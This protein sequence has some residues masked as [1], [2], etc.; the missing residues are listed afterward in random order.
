MTLRFFPHGMD[1]NPQLFREIKGRCT[2]RNLL[3][4]IAASAG[5]QALVMMSF[6]RLLPAVD[7]VT[8]TYC[9][10]MQDGYWRPNCVRD[11]LG[12]PLI[13]WP[14]WWSDSFQFLSWMLV[15]VGLM[16]GVYL[17]MGDL[18]KEE[19]R[20]TLNFIRLSPQSSQRILWGKLLGV[21]ILSYL[22]IA[23]A[24]PLHIYAGLQAG[25]SPLFILC[26]S[27][28]IAALASLHF[29][30]ALLLVSLGCRQ[31][32]VGVIAGC[33]TTFFLFTQWNHNQFIYPTP[34][35]PRYLPIA[36]WFYIDI[37][38]SLLRSTGFWI[39][40]LA[41]ATYWIWQAVNRHFRNPQSLLMSRGASYLATALFEIWVLGFTLRETSWG[42]SPL[43]EVGLFGLANLLWFVMLAAALTPSR[44]ALLDWAR[45][46]HSHRAAPGQSHQQNLLQDLLW[47]D[48]SPAPIP[49]AINFGI[50]LGGLT[51]WIISWG[52]DGAW[53][54][55]GLGA[56]ALGAVFIL[57]CTVIAQLILLGV[58]QN[59]LMI[60][61]ITVAGCIWLP[62]IMLAV[63]GHSPESAPF[64]WL[65]TAFGLA[66]VPF[67]S[68]TTLVGATLA[69]IA[70]LALIS[71]RLAQQLRA[72]GAS[73]FQSLMATRGD[74]SPS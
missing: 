28:G 38:H 14:L 53:Q 62:P 56:I 68:M 1:W 32:W 72:A 35:T 21:P 37:G 3:W 10:N 5:T 55:L 44:Q 6:R 48:K 40:S 15:V 47:N 12:Q 31:A 24:L 45:Y 70:L 57:T 8:N 60:A 43:E 69:Q 41:V 11:A 30:G 63:S 61:T 20:G 51:V 50:A 66:A 17:L 18:A 65:C 26:L 2:R 23:L 13:N 19:Q 49:L 9:T 73:E 52:W 64:L 59:R 33:I 39:I 67:A 4:A 16:A 71:G 46:R 27:L 54:W 22:A 42:R 34:D 74:R 58:G 7:A 25:Q 36:Q 29:V